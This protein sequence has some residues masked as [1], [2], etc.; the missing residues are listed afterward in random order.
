[1]PSYPSDGRAYIVNGAGAKTLFVE[2]TTQLEKALSVITDMPTLDSIVL[3]EGEPPPAAGSR[4]RPILSWAGL[5]TLGRDAR[6][7]LEPT[8]AERIATGPPGDVAT[9]VYT[10]GTTGHPKGAVPTP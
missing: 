10:S 7:R 3:V 9:I 2:D 5:R 4:A 1:Y 6:T 8:L